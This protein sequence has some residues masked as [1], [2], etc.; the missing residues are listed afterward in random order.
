MALVSR[1]GSPLFLFEERVSTRNGVL[2]FC[3]AEQVMTCDIVVLAGLLA[4]VVLSWLTWLGQNSLDVIGVWY[5]D[6]WRSRDA[7][8]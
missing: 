5:A 4:V 2:S 7:C 1:R 3:E 6:Y 8:R